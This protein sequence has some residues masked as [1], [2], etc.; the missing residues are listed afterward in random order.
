MLSDTSSAYAPGARRAPSTNATAWQVATPNGGLRSIDTR[1]G[2]VAVR[3]VTQTVTRIR[4]GQGGG[5][6]LTADRKVL[7]RD[8]RTNRIVAQVPGGF[9]GADLAVGAEGVWV[10]DQWQGAVFQ[11][12]PQTTR[13]VRSIRVVSRP[14]V[15]LD[16]RV[17]ADGDRG[18]LDGRH[19]ERSFS[20][21]RLGW[22]DQAPRSA[23]PGRAMA[24]GDAGYPCAPG[25]GGR[26]RPRSG[27][28]EDA[29]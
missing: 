17:L 2:A 24:S 8:P 10:Y 16:A 11:V 4:V 1:T 26:G 28:P 20:L 5:R 7:R 15:E 14:L 22:E 13:V 18:G 3:T 6:L 29:A 23:R 12:D 27:R 9:Q 19:R 25:L 21:P